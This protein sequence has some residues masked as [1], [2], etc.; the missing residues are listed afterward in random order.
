MKNRI[1]KTITAVLLFASF[2][3][4][5]SAKLSHDELSHLQKHAQ[6]IQTRA[7]FVKLAHQITM[8][9]LTEDELLA[10]FRRSSG[11]TLAIADRIITNVGVMNIPPTIL[12]PNRRQWNNHFLNREELRARVMQLIVALYARLFVNAQPENIKNYWNTVIG[13]DLDGIL[14]AIESGYARPEHREVTKAYLRSILEP[15]VHTVLNAYVLSPLDLGVD[16]KMRIFQYAV[17]LSNSHL[18][19][20]RMGVVIPYLRNNV[21]EIGAG[22]LDPLKYIAIGVG[23]LRSLINSQKLH[24]ESERPLYQQGDKIKVTTYPRLTKQT[25]KDIM[26]N[27]DC[28]ALLATHIATVETRFSN[29]K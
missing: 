9:P 21:L 27:I 20:A 8:T 18:G 15:I 16:L 28:Q 22:I 10:I 29:D 14:L 19:R 12:S 5:A 11:I 3:Q 6:N 7:D 24:Y 13:Y 4:F 1:Y 26:K 25:I 17:K 23:V 2:S